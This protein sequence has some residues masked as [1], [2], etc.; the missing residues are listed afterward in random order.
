M[1][2]NEVKRTCR[3]QK[4]LLLWALHSWTFSDLKG[5]GW[6]FSATGPLERE[7]GGLEEEK[8]EPMHARALM[9]ISLTQEKATNPGTTSR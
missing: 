7:T 5:L 2:E 6:F 1:K 9:C 3:K 4:R 8:G